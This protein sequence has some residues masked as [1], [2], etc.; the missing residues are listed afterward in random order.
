[1]K[2]YILG[3][4]FCFLT[5]S[6]FTPSV[7]YIVLR[8]VLSYDKILK[9]FKREKNTNIIKGEGLNGEVMANNLRDFTN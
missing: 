7:A 3:A 8:I 1:M 6:K 9:Y 4:L 5:D 2:S